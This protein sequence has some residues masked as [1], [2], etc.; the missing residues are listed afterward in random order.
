MKE[1]LAQFFVY[2]TRLV[3]QSNSFGDLSCTL[4]AYTLYSTTADDSA[5]Q[6]TIY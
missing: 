3:S 5:I 2:F 4:N 1:D 6:Y